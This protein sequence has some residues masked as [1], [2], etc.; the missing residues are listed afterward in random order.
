MAARNV[1]PAFIWKNPAKQQASKNIW[2]Q[3]DV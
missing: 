2:L 1:K 3:E